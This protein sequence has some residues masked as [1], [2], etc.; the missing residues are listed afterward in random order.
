MS[1]Q[2]IEQW[3]RVDDAGTVWVRTADGE[4]AVG[5]YPGVPPE[6]ALGYFARKY[7]ELA[8]QVQLLEQRVQAGQLPAKEA[9]AAIGKLRGSIAEG[10]AVGNLDALL[11]RLLDLVS[12]VES[13][14][15][16]QDAARAKSRDEARGT[17]ER[18]VTEAEELA[19]SSSWKSTGD[20]MR[21]LLAE[22]KAAP[23]LDRRTDDELWKRFS[24]ART[25]F[26]KRR[27]QHFSALDAQREESRARKERLIA[28]AEELSSSTD[29]AP[30]AARYRDLMTEWKAAGRAARDV[31]DELWQRFRGAQDRFFAARNEVFAE[32][33]AGQRGNL[34]RK[35]ALAAEAERLLPVTDLKAA[36]SALRGIV[37]RWDEIGHVPRD[38]K[39]RVESRLRRVEQAIRAAEEGEWRRTNPEARARAEATVNQLRTSIASFEATADK[40]RAAGNE[41]KATEATAA[42]A[43]RREWLAEAEK[44]LAEF[45]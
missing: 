19:S 6:E 28:E 26:D 37:E 7:D 16:E 39:E 9:Y 44:T 14:Q 36:K 15:A 17:K 21:E 29:W 27:K 41:R 10:H 20:R 1:S 30:T 5:S 38:A 12:L 33:D 8:G 18:I 45:S 24:A 22:W 13:R 43:A 42:A 11:V 32:R 34:E 35:E 2:G 4:R 40:A 25:T 23:R 31:D 3:G